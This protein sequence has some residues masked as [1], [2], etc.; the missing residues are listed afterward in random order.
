MHI[1]TTI[2]QQLQTAEAKALA[3]QG[4]AGLNVVPVSVITVTDRE[5]HLYDFFMRKTVENIKAEGTVALTAW[6]GLEGVQVRAMAEYV[7][8]G[9]VFTAAQTEMQE[10]FPERVLKGVVVLMP[11]AVYDISAGVERAGVLLAS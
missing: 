11:T 9:A 4:P 3:T 6:S 10:R 5:I 1:D 7:T 8:D 2:Q